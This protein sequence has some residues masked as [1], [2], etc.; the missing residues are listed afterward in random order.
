MRSNALKLVS[1]SAA[2]LGGK[3]FAVSFAIDSAQWR[4]L[5]CG[6]LGANVTADNPHGD[7]TVR[8][9]PTNLDNTRITVVPQEEQHRRVGVAAVYVID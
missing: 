1:R 2:G 5:F 4:W 3:T 7:I 6:R 9:W 8:Q